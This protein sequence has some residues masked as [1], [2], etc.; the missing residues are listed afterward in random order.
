LLGHQLDQA[1]AILDRVAGC[2]EQVERG[3]PARRDLAGHQ[4]E[5]GQPQDLALTHGNAARDLSDVFAKPDAD[6]QLF[7]VAKPASLGHARRVGG[8]LPYGLDVGG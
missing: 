1:R 6:D 2:D 8:K 7:Q 4:A 5:I 3:R